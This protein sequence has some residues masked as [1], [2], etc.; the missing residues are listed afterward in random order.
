VAASGAARTR[1][2]RIGA[3]STTTCLTAWAVSG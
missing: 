3:S 2:W 1:R